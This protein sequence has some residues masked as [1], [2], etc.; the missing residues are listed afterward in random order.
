MASIRRAAILRMAASAQQM[1]LDVFQGTVIAEE[2]QWSIG[3]RDLQQWLAAHAGEEV[4]IVLGSLAD[5][6]P[7]SV[8][9]CRKCGRDYSEME[10]PHCRMQR[11]RIRG[12]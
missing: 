12:R 1:E 8:Q 7:V 3:G 10:C 9:T 11:E 2:E 4:V 5:E 6:R